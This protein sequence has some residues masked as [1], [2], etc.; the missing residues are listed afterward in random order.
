MRTIALAVAAFLLTACASVEMAS[1]EYQTG[2]FPTI[3]EPATAVA[4]EVMASQWHFLTRGTAT[5]LAPAQGS[6]WIG[7]R[8]AAAGT[9]LLMAT[10]SGRTL[11]CQSRSIAAP[12]LHDSDDDQQ[13][14]RAY[15]INAYGFAVS[16]RNIDPVPYRLGSQSIL[17]GFKWQLIYQGIDAG[18]VRIAYREFTDDLAR[19]AF[20]QD[21]TYTLGADG[22]ATARFRDVAMT[23]HAADNNQIRYT[24][25]GG[26]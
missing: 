24:V 18:V 19:P 6:F 10:A 23:I 8:G 11:F 5:L 13:F 17:D 21:L 3:G 12:C 1:P 4:G 14:D 22:T 16:G 2:S 20:A 26:L 25:T 9:Q 15:T 7:R